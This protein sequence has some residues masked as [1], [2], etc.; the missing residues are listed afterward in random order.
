MGPGTLAL[1]A[2]NVAV[3]ALQS[4][5]GDQLT[6][7]FALWPYGT[8]DLQNGAT[9]ELFRYWQLVT[10]AFMHGGTTHLALNMFA[11]WMFGRDVETVLGTRGYLSL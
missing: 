10:S 8:F 4:V 11:L 5:I 9:I 6:L 7:T 1:I 3:F 2:A